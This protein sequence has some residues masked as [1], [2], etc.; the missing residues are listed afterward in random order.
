MKLSEIF[1]HLR[2]G[3]FARLHIGGR[4]DNGIEQECY[5]EVITHINLALTEVHKRLPIKM[6][7]VIVQQYDHIQNYR[8]SSEFAQ[9]NT[10]STQPIKYI[11]DSQYE[12]FEDDVLRVE[13]IINELGEDLFVNDPAQYWSVYV[14]ETTLIQVPAPVSDNVMSVIYRANH[15]QIPIDITD[16][17]QVEIEL[18]HSHLEPLLYYIGSRIYATQPTLDGVNEGNNYLAKFERSIQT[19]ERLNLVNKETP[20]NLRLESNNWV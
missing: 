20:T 18:S 8:L 6:K 4:E 10:T 9:S 1:N 15:R 12:P 17:D 14:P 7:E 13:R 19:I 3:E 5:P 2:F 16:P 11:E